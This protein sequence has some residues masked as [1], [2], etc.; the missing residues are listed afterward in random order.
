MVALSRTINFYILYNYFATENFF[1][2]IRLY[3]FKPRQ[4]KPYLSEG[5]FQQ[6]QNKRSAELII[7]MCKYIYIY[8]Y[9]LL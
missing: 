6:L 4:I 2:L 8:I 3:T 1:A 5:N 9:I 7:C